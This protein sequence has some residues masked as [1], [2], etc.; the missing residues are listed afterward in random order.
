MTELL[1]KML[2]SRFYILALFS[3]VALLLFAFYSITYSKATGLSINPSQP[4]V[5]LIIIAVSLIILGFISYIVKG[6]G[7]IT[8][9]VPFAPPVSNSEIIELL[10]T[11]TY[12]PSYEKGLISEPTRLEI[13]SNKMRDFDLSALKE[14]LNNNQDSMYTKAI[15][16]GCANGLI[17]IDRLNTSSFPQLEEV[18]GV[19]K[20]ES[21]I[22]EAIESA[23]QLPNNIPKYVFKCIDLESKEFSDFCN[24]YSEKFDLIFTSLTLH[25]LGEP[26][27]VLD[28]ASKLLR[29]GGIIIA[30]GV[31]DGSKIAYPKEANEYLQAV[32]S[33]TISN[34]ERVSDRFNGRRL[35]VFFRNAGF[36]NITMKYHVDD[37]LSL[38]SKEDRDKFFLSSFGF[39]LAYFQK[40][41]DSAKQNEKNEMKKRLDRM[42]QLLAGLRRQFRQKDLYYC[43]T[44][45]ICIGMKK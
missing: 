7:D 23:Q 18:W 22:F 24:S 44:A 36:I 10:R 29:K 9:K 38:L 11:S 25:H 43:E 42:K 12:D 45:Y 32:I 1:K 39:R 40:Q 35:P 41:L 33:Y 31:D 3:G 13:Q 4:N 8:E 20:E 27:T 34:A 37:T 17:T 26:L 15:D 30:R 28:N 6:K 21:G 14:V 5:T 16:L 2:S 19:D